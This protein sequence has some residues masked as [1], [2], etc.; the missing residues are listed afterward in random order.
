MSVGRK[1]NKGALFWVD[2][3]HF[4]HFCFLRRCLAERGSVPKQTGSLQV[5]REIV[6]V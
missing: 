5:H 4:S 6:T 2:F 3:E 1:G